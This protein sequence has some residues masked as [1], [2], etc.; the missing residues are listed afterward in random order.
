MKRIFLFITALLFVVA[1]HANEQSGAT[2]MPGGSTMTAQPDSR[3][4]ILLVMVDDMGWS[5]I[6]PF[7][8]EIETPNLDELNDTGVR[9]TNF[10]TSV[11]CSPTRAMLLS[12]NDNHVAGLGNMGELMTDTQR[13]Q[14]G[15]E[16]YL[17]ERV[18]SFAEVLGASGYHTY[19]AG[20]WHLG[21]TPET[22]PHGRGF[23]QSLALL[24]GGASHWSDMGGM[25]GGAEP[26]SSYA[27]NDKELE[28]LPDDFYS[29]RSYTDFIIDAIRQGRGDGKPFL[30]YLAYTT[31]HN[32]FHVPEPWLSQYRGDYDDG[33]EALKA[34]RTA[35]AIEMGLISTDAI[36]PGFYDSVKPWDSLSKEEQ[37]LSSRSME[38]YAGMVNNMDYHF[39]RMVNFLRDIDEFE[40]TIVIFLSDNGADP[41]F[42]EDY[43]TNRTEVGSQWLAAFDNSID[44]IGN[45][46]SH[47]AYGNGWASASAG[48]FDRFKMTVS[49]GGIRG[50][51]IVAGPG[52]ASGRQVDSLAYVWD[53]MAT[54]LDF[55]GA[56]YPDQIDGQAIEPMRGRSLKGVL[57]GTADSVYGSD[58]FLAGEMGNGM[59]VRLGDFKA[60][61][62]A[63]PYGDGAWRLYDLS[64][65]P[66]ETQDLA[67][68]RPDLL[69]E[70]Q[71]AWREY[72]D[73]VNLIMSNPSTASTP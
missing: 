52:I 44:N 40:N 61:A 3:P 9:F 26:V 66:G 25:M 15:Y 35:A 21:H 33:Y 38:V 43:P 1:T 64:D 8:S 54:M 68:Q 62:V 58:E 51:L 10:Y 65:D 59:W 71:A 7:G 24:S 42:M 49:E 17:N 14:P 63:P 56:D 19:M 36:T 16:G 37:D 32:P 12:G 2:N 34:R 39:G 29:T 45:P 18:A 22:F 20:K 31:P 69:E 50:P 11:S 47:F 70:L 6:G 28:E 5:D 4:N 41:W 27:L 57:T 13:G 72:A 53:I 46:G 60:V 23:E 67:K 30:A 73:D 55:A 48:P